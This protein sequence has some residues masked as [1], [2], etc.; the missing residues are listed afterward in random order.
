M[1]AIIFDYDGTVVLSQIAFKETLYELLKTLGLERV[2]GDSEIEYLARRTQKIWLP[3]ILSKLQHNRN[4]KPNIILEK[5]KDIY[6]RKH[7]HLIKP[8]PGIYDVLVEI[9]KKGYITVLTTSRI[10][11]ADFVPKELN[12]LGLSKLFDV[13][14][15]PKN[16]SKLEIFKH[17]LLKLK[18]KKAII[19]GDSIDDIVAGK[20]LLLKTVAVTY[21]FTERSEL[22]KYKPDYLI[23]EVR[24]L[25]KIV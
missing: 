9:R 1:N 2:F 11:V 22:V 20:A 12:Y 4:I 7:L 23:N 21:G 17:I 5:F 14:Y 8:A 18:T 16:P 3:E 25:L 19:V 10:L 15:I 13:V 24:E 6:S